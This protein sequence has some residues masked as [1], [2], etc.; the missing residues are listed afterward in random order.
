MKYLI[1]LMLTIRK[2]T[3]QI[4]IGGPQGNCSIENLTDTRETCSEEIT[5]FKN[6]IKLV[7][8]PQQRAQGQRSFWVGRPLQT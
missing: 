5:V 2:D 3:R 8:T 6:P 4:G 1:T 7:E